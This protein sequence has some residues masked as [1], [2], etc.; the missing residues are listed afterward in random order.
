MVPMDLGGRTALVCGASAGIGRA[1]A[2]ALARRGCAVVALARR[3]GG[4]GRPVCAELLAAGAP[5][6]RRA[7]GRPRRH[8]R[9]EGVQ[10]GRASTVADPDPQ[11]WRAARRARCLRPPARPSWSA[12]FTPARAVGAGAACTALLPAM[13]R[14]GLRPRGDGHL[15]HERARAAGQ[16]G[17]EQ[18]DPRG[19]GGRG[20]RRCRGS[21]R[22]ASRS[23]TSSRA[24]RPPSASTR[25]SRP[26]PRARAA[27][28]RRWS[29]PGSPPCPRGASPSRG[30]WARSSR[31]CAARRRRMCGGCRWRWTGD[32]CGR[33]EGGP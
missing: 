23:T 30:S 31:S 13:T 27:R 21:C 19:D 20:R 4:A 17:R 16:P 33:S 18:H 7:G 10:G 14:R 28:S 11:H 12:A 3:A 1:T 24:T 9:A 25:S 22:R 2:L 29:G 26:P 15:E 5:R 6:R 8:R 32:G